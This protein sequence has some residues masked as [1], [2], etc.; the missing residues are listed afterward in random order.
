MY[1]N[2]GLCRTIYC[3]CWVYEYHTSTIHTHAIP[4]TQSS[5]CPTIS[6]AAHFK[7]PSAISHQ[8]SASFSLTPHPRPFCHSPFAARAVCVPVSA[9]TDR[10]DELRC[11][12]S[13]FVSFRRFALPVPLYTLSTLVAL[14]SP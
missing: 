7:Q 10:T 2:A 6:P 13:R 3:T 14:Y 12:A 4:K 1:A 8:P 5:S 11:V 9:P